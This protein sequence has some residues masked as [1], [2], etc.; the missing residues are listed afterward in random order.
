MRSFPILNWT[1]F[2]NGRG[3]NLEKTPE[4]KA[5]FT[6]YM[7]QRRRAIADGTWK[8]AKRGKAADVSK[9]IPEAGK[10]IGDALAGLGE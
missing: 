10:T 9:G 7:R 6:A 5:K 4:Q 3:G 2:Y 8:P 1:M